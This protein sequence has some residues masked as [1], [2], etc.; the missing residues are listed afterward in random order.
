LDTKE[1]KQ[2]DDVDVPEGPVQATFLDGYFYVIEDNS[3]RVHT[4]AAAFDPAGEWDALDQATAEYEGD[5]LISL[6]THN[7]RL[8]MFGDRTIEV[9]EP[10]GVGSFPI[11]P[12]PNAFM[13]IGC[14]AAHSPIS[15]GNNLYFL[16][17]EHDGGGAIAT[18]LEGI[19]PQRVSTEEVEYEWSTYKRVDD[20]YSLLWTWGS[21]P[22]WIIT[23]PTAKRT[24]VY[25]PAIPDEELRW[26]EFGTYHENEQQWFQH[27]AASAVSVHD[28]SNKETV[29]M[30]DFVNGNVY[31]GDEGAMDDDG[32]PIIS[33][34]TSQEIGAFSEIPTVHPMVYL[35]METG[36]A[37]YTTLDPQIGLRYTD[38]H[39]HT[40]TQREWISYGKVGEHTKWVSWNRLGASPH[41]IYEFTM[42]HPVQR[43]ISMGFVGHPRNVDNAAG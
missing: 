25:D 34:V 43:A 30:G 35:R 3:A 26:S 39:G 32:V 5:Y 9:W 8:Y 29:I 4:H 31:L 20:A 27:R 36:V 12:N 33:V 15:L 11:R 18:K 2:V 6:F 19:T 28:A 7:A 10:S 22:L 23:F 41:R 17:H 1:Y 24:W 13:E 37:D 42:H 21:H 14:A 38:D 40:W 16:S